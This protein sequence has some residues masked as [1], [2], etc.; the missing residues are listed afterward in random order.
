MLENPM[1]AGYSIPRQRQPSVAGRCEKCRCAVYAGE[2]VYN[3]KNQ[4][5]CDCCLEE[6]VHGMTADEIASE[7]DIE[8]EEK[9]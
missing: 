8:T 7:F 5:I 2:R 4:S 9:E 1:V 6:A 3:Y